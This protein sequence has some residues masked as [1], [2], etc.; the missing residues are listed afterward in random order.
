[1]TT[2]TLA[3][4]GGD[5]AAVFATLVHIREDAAELYRAID[6]AFNEIENFPAFG[7]RWQGNASG[8]RSQ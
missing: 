7:Y 5:L 3:S 1:M 6:D 2:P 4:D 8:D